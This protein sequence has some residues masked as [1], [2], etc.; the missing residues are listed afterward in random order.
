MPKTNKYALKAQKTLRKA[1]P[2]AGKMTKGKGFSP[3][4][5]KRY[6]NVFKRVTKSIF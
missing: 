5:R 2:N 6:K 4:E 1:R 3:M